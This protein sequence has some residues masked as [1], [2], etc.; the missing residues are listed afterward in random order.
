MRLKFDIQRPPPHL[1]VPTGTHTAKDR[2]IFDTYNKASY[3]AKK[4]GH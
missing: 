3:T 2:N 4:V 1:P